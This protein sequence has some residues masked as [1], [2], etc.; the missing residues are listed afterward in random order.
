RHRN[1]LDDPVHGGTLVHPVLTHPSLEG[2]E[3]PAHLVRDPEVV[4]VDLTKALEDR[5]EAPR[6]P[7]PGVRE[8]DDLDWRL[9]F[10]RQDKPSLGGHARERLGEPPTSGSPCRRD[11][12]ATGP[13]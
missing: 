3:L 12:V 6:P 1:G 7:A 2:L 8:M 5:L 10:L 9:S 11:P 13:P 4:A